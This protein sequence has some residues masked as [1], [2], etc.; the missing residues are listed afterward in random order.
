MVERKQSLERKFKSTSDT[1]FYRFLQVP[2][3]ILLRHEINTN[4]F[5]K[6]CKYTLAS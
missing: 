5:M 4:N 3:G 6:D 1:S 2:T